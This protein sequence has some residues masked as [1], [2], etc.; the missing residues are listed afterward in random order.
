MYFFTTNFTCKLLIL[1][2][3]RIRSEVADKLGDGPLTMHVIAGNVLFIG[4]VL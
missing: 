4:H 3:A 2:V 1:V